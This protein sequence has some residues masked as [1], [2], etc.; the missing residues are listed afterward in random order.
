M[1][2][3]RRK[4]LKWIDE[5]FIHRAKKIGEKRG[6]SENEVLKMA[7]HF[8]MEFLER[9]ID[10]F[11]EIRKIKEE[12]EKLKGREDKKKSKVDPF[13]ERLVEEV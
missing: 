9:E 13:I 11:E 1:G 12:I 10:V 2:V 7:L 6:L 8:G 5:S 3:K 4:K